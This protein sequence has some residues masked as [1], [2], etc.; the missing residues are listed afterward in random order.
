MTIRHKT[1]TRQGSVMMET[2]LILPW[3][4]LVVFGVVQFSFLWVARLMT[5]YAAFCAARAALVYNPAD[6][7]CDNATNVSYQAARQILA[8]MSFSTPHM[9]GDAPTVPGW[10]T[11]PLSGDIDRQLHVEV[12]NET[13]G[14]VTATV[15]FAFPLFVPVV[16]KLV[17]AM[18]DEDAGY[19][20]AVTLSAS[21]TLPKPWSTEAWPVR[22]PKNASKGST[23]LIPRAGSAG[24]PYL[25][26]R[27]L[28]H[29]TPRGRASRPEGQG[30]SKGAPPAPTKREMQA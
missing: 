20:N 23:A 10:E 17:P 2:V 18:I 26:P 21:C 1:T 4:L 29:L 28:E 22:S 8:W 6:T 24:V 27:D 5:D 12:D 13:E 15:H 14:F 30:V 3:F 11:I 7:T 25:S 19:P 9:G 16:S